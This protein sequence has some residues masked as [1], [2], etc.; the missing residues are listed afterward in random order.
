MI[1]GCCYAADANLMSV[2]ACEIS[3]TIQGISWFVDT[4]LFCR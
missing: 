1:C 3:Y 2:A 4:L